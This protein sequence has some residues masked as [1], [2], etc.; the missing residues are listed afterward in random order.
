MESYGRPAFQAERGKNGLA[1]IFQD[2]EEVSSDL[3]R[4]QKKGSK[5]Q[6]GRQGPVTKASWAT[7]AGPGF[8]RI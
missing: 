4:K 7:T 2:L 3:S 5:D 8:L 6:R 1:S